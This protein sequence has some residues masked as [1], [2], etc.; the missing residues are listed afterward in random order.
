MMLI[1]AW[2]ISPQDVNVFK[3]ITGVEGNLKEFKKINALLR[4]YPVYSPF[5]LSDMRK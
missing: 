1:L 4:K 2:V 3:G 5:D